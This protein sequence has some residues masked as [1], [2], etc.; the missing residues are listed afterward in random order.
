MNKLI[1]KKQI[2]DLCK[3]LFYFYSIFQI[4]SF[5]YFA[6]IQSKI[7]IN[8]SIWLLLN[9]CVLSFISI[10]NIV[11]SNILCFI[12]INSFVNSNI[13]YQAFQFTLYYLIKYISKTKSLLN[14]QFNFQLFKTLYLH[15]TS[16]MPY[17]IIYVY[18]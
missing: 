11:S 5:C 16:Y 7:F 9:F 17:Q 6:L 10:N 13:W 1:G 15:R 12:D 4:Y 18:I 8:Y 3:H 14:Y 2:Q